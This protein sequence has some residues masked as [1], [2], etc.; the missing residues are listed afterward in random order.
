MSGS[1]SIMY[2]LKAVG[3]LIVFAVGFVA[4]DLVKYADVIP[5]QYKGYATGFIALA[6]LIG[7]YHAPYAALGQHRGPTAKLGGRTG[8][9]EKGLDPK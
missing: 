1:P 5:P 8:S 6:T 3:K 4:A 9:R 2:R 7:A